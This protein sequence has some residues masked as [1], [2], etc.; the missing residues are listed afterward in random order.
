VLRIARSLV[1]EMI[2]HARREAPDECW[3]LLAGRGGQVLG[4][5]PCENGADPA[6]RPFRYVTEPRSQRL[7][8][9]AI[10]ARGWAIVGIYHSHTHTQ[11]YP[12]PTDIGEANP[13]LGDIAYVLVSLRAARQPFV[14]RGMSQEAW[15]R[16]HDFA[17][18]RPA[19]P[20]VCAF[21]IRDGAAEQVGLRLSRGVTGRRLAPWREPA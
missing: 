14:Y 3:G 10:G 4:V 5:F 21:H 7:A 6:D 17:Q 9:D 8:D 15:Q 16:A 13:F 20:E 11:P 2:S 19:R 12:S 18:R 1:D